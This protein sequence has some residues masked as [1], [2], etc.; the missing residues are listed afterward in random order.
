MPPPIPHPPPPIPHPYRRL[1]HLHRNALAL[2]T[3]ATR[4]PASARGQVRFHGRGKVGGYGSD[5]ERFADEIAQRTT[6]SCIMNRMTE[7]IRA[8]PLSVWTCSSVPS[9]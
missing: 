3:F 5:I 8:K 1:R 6:N 7:L 2:S 9:E 4:A